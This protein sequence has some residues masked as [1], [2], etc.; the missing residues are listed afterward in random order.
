MDDDGKVRGWP[1]IVGFN[2]FCRSACIRA[3]WLSS[4]RCIQPVGG[5]CCGIGGGTNSDPLDRAACRRATAASCAALSWSPSSPECIQPRGGNDGEDILLL[6]RNLLIGQRA[7]A[8]GRAP[9]ARSSQLCPAA[10][11]AP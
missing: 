6:L 3:T 10:W 2:L 7:G 11:Q 1:S 8:T 9:D 5:C 4:D